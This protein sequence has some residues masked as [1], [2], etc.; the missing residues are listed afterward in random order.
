[1]A[2][3]GAAAPAGGTAG[4]FLGGVITE[5]L[6]WPWVFIIYIPIGLASL[7]LVPKLLPAVPGRRTGLDVAGAIAVT[8]G[9][10][11]AVYAI[12]QAPQRGWSSTGAVLQLGGAVLLLAAFVAVQKAAR[13]PLMPLSVWRTPGLASANVAMTLLGAAWI[14]MWYFLNLYLQ[15]VLGF[16]AFPSG[17]ALVP[18]TGLM[19]ILMIGVTGRLIARFGTKPLIVTGLAVLAAGL[20]VLSTIEPDGGFLTDVLPG[21]LISAVGMS[22]VFIPAM[23]AAIGAAAPEQG[24]LASGIVNTTY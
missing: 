3:Y 9:L 15:Q 14:P 7:A 16:G 18:M 8:G 17:A 13:N 19:M 2:V 11:L 12:V 4:V 6:S 21:S 5:W 1:M 22:L 24:G 10:A 23:M 20:G